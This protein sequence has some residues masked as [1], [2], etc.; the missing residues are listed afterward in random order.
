MVSN[1]LFLFF[2]TY[3]IFFVFST[4]VLVMIKIQKAIHG[5]LVLLQIQLNFLKF[6]LD[7]PN[8]CES[9]FIDIYPEK[10]DSQSRIHNFCGSI[11][12]MVLSKSNILHVRFMAEPKAI[13]SSFSILY[14][15]FREKKKDEG[16]SVVLWFN[17]KA[18]TSEHGSPY[19]YSILQI[20]NK[21]AFNTIRV[22]DC[23]NSDI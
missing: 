9:N 6:S 3:L 10:T 21:F 5:I 7:Q 14:T 18:P 16:K 11:A 4:E 2:I 20:N 23:I 1:T 22:E 17:H 15:A 8:D 12:V 13:N 19:N